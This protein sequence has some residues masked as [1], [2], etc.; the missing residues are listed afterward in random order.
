MTAG[1]ATEYDLDLPAAVFGFGTAALCGS[2]NARWPFPT[3]ASVPTKMNDCIGSHPIPSG[4]HAVLLV[5]NA[6]TRGE[7][8]KRSSDVPVLGEE[9][10][11]S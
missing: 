4:E 5:H 9:I 10:Q 2:L 1:E 11:V 3:S 8:R 7:P 6:S